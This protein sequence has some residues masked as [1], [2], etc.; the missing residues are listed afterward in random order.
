MSAVP[1]ARVSRSRRDHQAATGHP[2]AQWRLHSI[3]AGSGAT[4]Q[5]I[6][7]DRPAIDVTI[8]AGSK[9][10]DRRNPRPVALEMTDEPVS[11]RFVY[12]AFCQLGYEL[13]QFCRGVAAA[14]EATK[15]QFL[16]SGGRVIAVYEDPDGRA[17]AAARDQY[18][19]SVGIDRLPLTEEPAC[20]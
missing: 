8:V 7:A 14:T 3:R 15:M 17:Q 16:Y 1:R 11:S 18:M 2:A 4:I 12:D 9:A 13:E 5:A 20:P 10:H 6:P 19:R